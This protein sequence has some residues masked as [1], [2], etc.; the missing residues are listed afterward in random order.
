[1]KK[2]IEEKQM[3]PKQTSS[4]AQGPEEAG[5]SHRLDY[6][7]SEDAFRAGWAAC[8]GVQAAAQYG[9]ESAPR[10]V[11]EAL[12]EWQTRPGAKR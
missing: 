6:P 4:T 3:T 11:D 9:D 1:M 8:F 10:T 12:L 7:T 5:T 2:S